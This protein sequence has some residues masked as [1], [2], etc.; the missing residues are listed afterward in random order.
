[1]TRRMPIDFRQFLIRHQ[2]LFLNLHTW[3]VRLLVPRRFRKAVALYKALSASNSGRPWT[4]ASA[5]RWRHT[6]ASG[7]NAADTLPSLVIGSSPGSSNGREWRRSRRCI[8]HG[9]ERETWSCGGRRQRLFA[10]SGCTAVRSARFRISTPN[11]CSSPG[12]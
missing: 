5:R 9:G 12:P 7:G 10:M 3:S 6:S 2:T 4:R 11:T 8:E 1:V